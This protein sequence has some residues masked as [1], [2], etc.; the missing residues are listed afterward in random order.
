MKKI[1]IV[2][3]ANIKNELSCPAVGCLA[4]MNTRKGAFERYKEEGLELVGMTTCAGC[5]TLLAPDKIL[6]KIK[7]LV[8]LAEAQVLHLSTC[9]INICPFIKKYQSIIRK[10]YPELE[11]VSGT[12]DMGEKVLIKLG[13][14]VKTM[15][16]EG[17]PDITE[18]YLK[19]VPMEE[20]RK[21]LSA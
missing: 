13:M 19:A 6:T 2:T 20:F 10:K 1:A 14:A 21:S 12:D 16:T 5:P 9:M 11:I 18:E 17:Q 7:P 15:L 8:E 3:C 4:Y